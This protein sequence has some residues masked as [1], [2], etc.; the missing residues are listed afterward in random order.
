MINTKITHGTAVFGGT[1]DPVHNAHLALADYVLEHGFAENILFMPA[2]TPPHKLLK[3]IS[4]YETRREMLS[5]ALEGKTHCAISDIERERTGSSYTVDTLKILSQ[6]STCNDILLL[7][8]A[9]SLRD[10][11]LWRNPREILKHS[12][13]LVYP[14]KGVEI[15]LEELLRHWDAET[16]ELLYRSVMKDAPS[17]DVSSTEIRRLAALKCFE[18]LS[19]MVP[20]C[21]AEYIKTHNLYSS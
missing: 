7:T 5:L 16:A 19:G 12:R 13:L 3:K 15:T 17:S 2:P 1:F 9:D 4:S 10:F 14:R 21:V 11:H 8:G 6:N 20:P 18:K